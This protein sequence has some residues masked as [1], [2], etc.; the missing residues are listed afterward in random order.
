MGLVLTIAASGGLFGCTSKSSPDPVEAEL[1]LLR[2]EVRALHEEIEA[3]RADLISV[4]PESE[5]LDS[6]DITIEQPL[7][8]REAETE[9]VARPVEHGPPAEAAIVAVL[10]AYARAIESEDLQLLRELY[11]GEVPQEDLRY[12]EIWLE[13]TDNLQVAGD[14]TSIELQEDAA[15]AEVSFTMTFRFKRTNELRVA[16]LKVPMQLVYSGGAWHVTSAKLR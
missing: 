10:D 1:A 16:R 14:P 6:V 4:A 9:P 2:E 5:A 8:E 13:R 3:L 12:V 7:A 11:G 15:R